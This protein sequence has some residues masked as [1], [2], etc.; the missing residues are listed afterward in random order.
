VGGFTLV[1]LL[2]VIAIIGILIG[3]LL[4]AVQAA[5]EAA[6]R[7]QCTNNLKQMGLAVHNHELTFRA[8]PNGGDHFTSGRQL[9]NGRPAS[10]PSQTWGWAYQILPWMEQENVWAELD[11]AKVRQAILPAYFCPS[12]RGPTIYGGSTLLDYGGNGGDGSEGDANHTGPIARFTTH[13]RP[14]DVQDGMSNTIL[15]G[16]KYLNS[17]WRQGGTWGDNTGYYSG[18]GWDTIRFGRQQPRQDAPGEQTGT[19]DLFGSAHPGGFQAVLCD[20]SV[21]VLSYTVNNTVIRRL[22]NRQD[23]QVID[24]SQL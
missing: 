22:A 5:R 1:E 16:E 23:G 17:N 21:R 11:N 8:F 2:V 4:P 6:R 19:Y 9:A 10:V 13:L 12:R 18:W 14:R 20:G 7:S 15:I 3:L 24:L